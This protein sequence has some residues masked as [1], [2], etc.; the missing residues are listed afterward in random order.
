MTAGADLSARWLT[1][2]ATERRLS[3]H[4]L[5]AYAGSVGRFLDFLGHLHGRSVDAAL[6]AVL[7]T[8]DIRSF[9]A[10][11]RG[12]DGLSAAS[13]AREMAA[14]RGFD[15][16]LRDRNQQGIAGLSRVASPRVRK[17]LPRP[18]APADAV[19]L[20]EGA[21]AMAEADWVAARDRAVLL[22]LYGAG[23]R[24][25]EAM[26]L[27]S[28]ILP[29]G[30]TLAV[31][32]KG[33]RSRLVVLLPA[34]RA[35]VEAY[36]R[37]APYDFRRGEPLF[38]GEKGGPL[39]AGLVRRA[40]RQARAGMNLPATATPHALR[41]SFATHLLAAGADL[42]TL[43]DLLGHASLSSTQIYTG[44]DPARLLDIYR[45]AHPRA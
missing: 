36:V 23:L 31:T 11:R 24:I 34:V 33:R 19:G 12:R 18:L 1:T 35:A 27:D 32:G 20:V 5:R 8:A 42:R 6:L 44:V 26:E 17:R 21:A 4:T 43:Q 13:A 2:L 22:L 29:L 15:R 3:P 25:G 45:T 14:L 9:L 28:G 10:M 38:R 16:W 39:S 41:H 37:M 30:E 7:T 40:V